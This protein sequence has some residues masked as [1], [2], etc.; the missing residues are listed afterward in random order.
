MTYD[1]TN[2]SDARFVDYVNT[3]NFSVAPTAPQPP[4]DAGPEGVAFISADDSP[5]GKPLL[6]VGHRDQRHDHADA[7]HRRL[8]P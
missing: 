2:P 3:R 6:V 4:T 8:V 7:R 5:N 1:V